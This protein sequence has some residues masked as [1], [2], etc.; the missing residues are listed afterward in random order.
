MQ[1][2]KTGPNC[3]KLPS[4]ERLFAARCHR[5]KQFVIVMLFTADDAVRWYVVC[6]LVLVV[7]LAVLVFVAALVLWRR[8]RRR[9]RRRACSTSLCSAI[10]NGGPLHDASKSLSSH[11]GSLLSSM[12]SSLVKS[13]LAPQSYFLQ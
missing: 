9:R 7:L 2:P 1:L 13:P 10:R 3:L 5:D 6:V 8:R 11:P 12:A 4:S